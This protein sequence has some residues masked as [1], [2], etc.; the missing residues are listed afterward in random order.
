MPVK[1]T[2]YGIVL[3]NLNIICGWNI[4]NSRIIKDRESCRLW[5]QL[6]QWNNI[7]CKWNKKLRVYIVIP[8]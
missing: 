1:V 7:K 6:L 2:T 4:Y 5:T 3:Q 8:R